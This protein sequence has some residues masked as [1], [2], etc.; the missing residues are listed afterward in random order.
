MAADPNDANT[1]GN[2]GQL[3]V[4]LGRLSEGEEALLTASLHVHP[5]HTLLMAEL[6]FSL[7]LVSRMQHRDA[8]RWERGFK[9]LIQQ[10]FG[11]A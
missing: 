7:W 8:D 6:S 5:S 9:F 4:G 10:G 11:V 2:Y 1:L 3:L